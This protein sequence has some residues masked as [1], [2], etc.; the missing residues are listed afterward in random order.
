MIGVVIALAL[1]LLFVT[2]LGKPFGAGAEA[3]ARGVSAVLSPQIRPTLAPMIGL[4]FGGVIQ[5]WWEGAK[6][7]LVGLGIKPKY[8]EVV[9]FKPTTL[10]LLGYGTMAIPQ[11]PRMFRGRM[12]GQDGSAL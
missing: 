5:D 1:G 12:Y 3:I 11:S 4:E 9:P 10:P 8:A 7:W 6:A 2:F